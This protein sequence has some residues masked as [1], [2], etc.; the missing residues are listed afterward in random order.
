MKFSTLFFSALASAAFASDVVDLSSSADEFNKFIKSKP[1]VLAKFFAPWCG[2]CKKLAPEY[3]TA[4]TALKSKDIA[5]AE[6]DCT[7]NKDLCSSFKIQGYP[8][9]LIFRGLDEQNPY[10]GG[11]TSKDIVNYME[12]ELLPAWTNVKAD[13]VDKF[14]DGEDE[15]S[16]LGLFEPSDKKSNSSLSAIARQMHHQFSIGLS[17][18]KAVFDKFEIETLPAVILNLKT[19]DETIVLSDDT[20]PKFSLDPEYILGKA[21]SAQIVPAGE[22]SPETF[23]GYMASGLPLAYYFYNEEADRDAI[24]NE[25]LEL[26]KEVKADLNIGFIDAKAFG[27]HAPNLN[28]NDKE[29]PAFAIHDMKGNYKYPILPQDKVPT[30]DEIIKHVREFVAGK[31]TPNVKSEPIPKKQ[32]GPV[33][34]VVGKSFKDDVLDNDKDVLVEFYAPWCGH[35]K[36]LA[37]TYEELASLY[38]NDATASGKV[39]VAKIDHTAN[40]IAGLEIQG[41]PTLILYPAGKKDSPIRYESG[42]RTLDDLSA[43][44]RDKGTHGVDSSVLKKA[45]K[46]KTKKSKKSKRSKKAKKAKK[47][48]GDEL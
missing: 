6:I 24:R 14:L 5:L 44:I 4:A 38:A 20:D 23:R 42:S 32:D 29:F 40:E 1:I 27:A 46:I 48:G 36:N 16:I 11:R 18:D 26:A 47:V 25:I 12:R 43:F 41:Y 28:L 39:R 30:P 21:L 13:N 15:V 34:V 3:E 31:L 2:H 19:A 35:C 8:T 22:I 33:H 7:V 45:S 10:N 17:S 37:P 9:L